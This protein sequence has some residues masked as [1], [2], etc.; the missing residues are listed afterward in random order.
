MAVVRQGPS[1]ADTARARCGGFRRC[2]AKDQV[3]LRTLGSSRSTS[4]FCASLLEIRLSDIF[5]AEMPG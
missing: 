4:T 1:V 5:L 3:Q 2:V